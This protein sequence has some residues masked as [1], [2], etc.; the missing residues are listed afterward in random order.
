MTIKEKT[1]RIFTVIIEKHLDYL[2]KNLSLQSKKNLV[3]LWLKENN[4][5][6]LQTVRVIPNPNIL[7]L[8]KK[9]NKSYER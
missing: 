9:G 6:P 7:Y 2:Q 3:K 4:Y 8:K 5:K 1:E